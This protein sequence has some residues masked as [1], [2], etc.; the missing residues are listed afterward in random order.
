LDALY[1]SV[2]ERTP[3][4]PD[5]EE[6]W[7]KNKTARYVRIAETFHTSFKMSNE[8]VKQARLILR[9]AFKYR[10]WA[11]HPPAKFQQPLYYDAIDAG[12]EWRFL[13]FGA[14][15][16]REILRGVTQLIE[17][18]L[19]NPRPKFAELV[20][21]AEAS[22][23]QMPVAAK[24]FTVSEDQSR[25]AGEQ[26]TPTTDSGGTGPGPNPGAHGA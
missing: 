18:I 16:A 23:L 13:A 9:E 17:Y 21:W 2:K 10:D 11:V 1:A 8:A 14:H 24:R 3:R 20:K 19:R 7:R 25:S 6:V 5:L 26:A 15:N 22:K 4:R 12:A